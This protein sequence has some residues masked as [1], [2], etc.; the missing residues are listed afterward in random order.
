MGDE[1]DGE[2]GVNFGVHGQSFL[3]LARNS[4]KGTSLKLM[5]KGL[6]FNE[7]DCPDG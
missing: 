2:S 1:F 7:F 4:E 5:L 3:G 6:R